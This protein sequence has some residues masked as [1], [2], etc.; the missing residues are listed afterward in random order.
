MRGLLAAALVETVLVTYRDLSKEKLQFPLPC[1]YVAIAMIYG[2][3]SLFPETA[4]N[5][6]QLVGWGFVVATFLNFWDPTKPL[7]VGGK[8]PTT[9]TQ[10]APA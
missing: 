4:G 8:G 6:T 3:L 1:D 5:F 7:A 2:G 9:K 10:G